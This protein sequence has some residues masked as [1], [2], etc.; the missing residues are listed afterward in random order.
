[1]REGEITKIMGGEHRR[2]NSYL[3]KFLEENKKGF[4]NIFRDNIKRHFD[5]EEE[6]IFLLIK[7]FI[8]K[9]QEDVYHLKQQH[10]EILEK[11][12]EVEK[13]ISKKQSDLID[14]L[15]KFMAGH[16]KFEEKNFYPDMDDLLEQERTYKRDDLKIK[17]YLYFSMI[18]SALFFIFSKVVLSI[19]SGQSLQRTNLLRF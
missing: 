19:G 7:K 17:N 2:I 14:T 18:F 9:E 15:V 16:V 1:M 8:G 4:F 3:N 13:K 5:V 11:V 12:K 10:K 6:A